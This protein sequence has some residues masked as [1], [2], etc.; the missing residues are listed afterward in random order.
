MGVVIRIFTYLG[1]DEETPIVRFYGVEKAF[2]KAFKGDINI[3][4]ENLPGDIMKEYSRGEEAYI[5]GTKKPEAILQEEETWNKRLEEDVVQNFKKLE[6]SA[7]ENGFEKLSDYF[8]NLFY[9][10]R[11]TPY[12]WCLWS[13]MRNMDDIFG[14]GAEYAVC[15]RDDNWT[16]MMPK[17]VLEDVR[18]H[19][20]QY[21]IV[22]LVYD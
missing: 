17:D 9:T 12:S 3:I 4:K 8:K 7:A 1:D 11:R 21:A 10:E 15:D 13:S 18:R 5:V 22:K 2:Y 6:N 14:Y 16:V 20:E 19:P